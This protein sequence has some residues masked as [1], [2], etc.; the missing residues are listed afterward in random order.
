MQWGFHFSGK[1]YTGLYSLSKIL[2]LVRA[3]RTSTHA[4]QEKR[5]WR[6][7]G[8]SRG[9]DTDALLPHSSLDDSCGAAKHHLRCS[10]R[11][12]SP[13]QTVLWSETYDVGGLFGPRTFL[14][15]Y[16]LSREAELLDGV[17]A[18]SRG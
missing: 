18:C 1:G 4:W 10:R 7:G 2:T 8:A 16:L 6:A 5:S 17:D 15:S 14:S 11:T 12:R 3:A 13:S 9:S